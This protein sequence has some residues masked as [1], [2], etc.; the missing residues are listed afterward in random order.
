MFGYK[1][2]EMRGRERNIKHSAEEEEEEH[3]FIRQYQYLGPQQIIWAATRAIMRVE[4]GASLHSTG[5]LQQ[6]VL[7]KYQKRLYNTLTV[8]FQAELPH[9][10]HVGIDHP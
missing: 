4:M 3:L 7:S 9:V 8:A 6:Q 1:S 10:G 5:L 2:R